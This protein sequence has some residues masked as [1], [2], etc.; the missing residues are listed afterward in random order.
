MSL[1][2]F[3]LIGLALFMIHE[4]DEIILVRIYLN[5]AENLPEPHGSWWN[6]RSAYP[7]TE[8]ISMGIAEEFFI[9]AI[10]LALAV[11][12]DIPEM[13]IGILI[14]H[15]FHI[16]SHIVD[17]LRVGRWVP[18]SLTAVITFPLLIG[19]GVWLILT[20][21]LSWIW[22]LIWAV[23]LTV[24]LFSNLRLMWSAII[25]RTQKWLD[26]VY[27]PDPAGA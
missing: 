27:Q 1:A 7:S 8:A 20:N 3:A 23:V 22:T 10:G 12:L 13:A 26:Q 5:R 2:L 19:S 18:G 21:D 6:N 14:P 25:S 16:M 11:S 17:A 24:A 15:C 9:S 4:F